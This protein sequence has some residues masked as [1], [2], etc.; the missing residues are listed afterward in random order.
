MTNEDLDRCIDA[1]A[2]FIANWL[3]EISGGLYRPAVRK[4]TPKQL[5][6]LMVDAVAF[7]KSRVK[8]YNLIHYYKLYIILLD[9]LK[10]REKN[11][12]SEE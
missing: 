5:E 12:A 3:K 8:L 1:Y 4:L 9:R 11:E 7:T 10:G 6:W 2:N